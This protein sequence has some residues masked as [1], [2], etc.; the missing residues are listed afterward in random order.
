MESFSIIDKFNNDK[1]T[2]AFFEN[3]DKLSMKTKGAEEKFFL[4][5]SSTLK[6]LVGMHLNK[7][8]F[9]LKNL[10]EDCLN[11]IP[12]K[13]CEIDRKNLCSE[14]KK[15]INIAHAEALKT[16]KTQEKI[17]IKDF[18]D[19]EKPLLKRKNV[20]K[21]EVNQFIREVQLK[22]DA[23]SIIKNLILIGAKESLSEKGHRKFSLHGRFTVVPYHG[24]SGEIGFA[25]RRSIIEQIIG[26]D[27]N[28]IY[29]SD[30]NSEEL[31]GY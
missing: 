19:P 27:W 12:K 26:E 6:R 20:F 23:G 31:K 28:E 8:S 2:E 25:L 5:K 13:I 29:S 9:Q 4:E 3:V 18:D 21:D 16:A 17:E 1:Y 30:E 15:I 7:K 10:S 11:L 14:V 24:K 22:G